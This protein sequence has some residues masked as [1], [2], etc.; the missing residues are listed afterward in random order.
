[1]ACYKLFFLQIK[2]YICIMN[3]DEYIV[4]VPTGDIIWISY[5][6]KNML[7]AYN[8]LGYQKGEDY[9][10]FHNIKRKNIENILEYNRKMNDKMKNG[11]N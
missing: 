1:M 11:V 3:R 7:L 4:E 5:H 10:F 9:W 8:M 2:Y 6:E